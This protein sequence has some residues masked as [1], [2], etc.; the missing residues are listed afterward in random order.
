M[1]FCYTSWQ[2]DRY[3]DAQDAWEQACESYMESDNF[4]IDMAEWVAFVM[5]DEPDRPI[6]TEEDFIAYGMENYVEQWIEAG[7]EY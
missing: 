7:K 1:G 6:P 5:E 2:T 3:L 4:A